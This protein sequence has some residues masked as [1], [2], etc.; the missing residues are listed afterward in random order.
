[1][2]H[3]VH[4]RAIIISVIRLGAWYKSRASGQYRVS[5]FWNLNVSL[6]IVNKDYLPQQ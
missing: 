2:Q 3:A 1:M 5:Q 6:I 4:S